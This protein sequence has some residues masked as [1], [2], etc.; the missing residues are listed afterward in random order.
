VVDSTAPA[1]WLAALEEHPAMHGY[2]TP[3]SLRAFFQN[4][5]LKIQELIHIRQT[6]A[7]RVLQEMGFKGILTFMFR[8]YPKIIARMIRD[9]RIRE[10]GKID[11]RITKEGKDYL[12]YVLLI[13]GK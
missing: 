8:V 3:E 13:A 4:A 2:F 11:D 1:D 7:P 5:G 12:G 9:P 6:E 10:A